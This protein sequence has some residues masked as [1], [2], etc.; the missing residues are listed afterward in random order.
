M[1]S[2]LALKQTWAETRPYVIFAVILFF[3]GVMVGGAAHGSLGWLDSQIAAL[4][5]LADKASSSA[6]PRLTFFKTIL[7]NNMY[8]TILSL[9]LGLVAAIMPILMLVLNGVVLGYLFGLAADGGANVWMIFVK[10]ILPHGIFE[11][12]AIFLACGYGIR[13]GIQVIR[14]IGGSLFGRADPWASV[15]RM[16]KMSVPVVLF[17]AALLLIAALLES[18]LTYW[19]V[20]A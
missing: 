15:S 8:K 10:G 12:P 14:G 2:R 9:Y 16:L 3:A 11:L 17:I 5:K 7:E 6:H 13:L 1:F 4:E 20:R 19:L 18:T